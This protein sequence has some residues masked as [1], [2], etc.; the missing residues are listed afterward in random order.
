MDF[1]VHCAAAVP[2]HQAASGSQYSPL[3]CGDRRCFQT[4]TTTTL[5]SPPLP[6][7][8]VVKRKFDDLESCCAAEDSN[9]R[10]KEASGT[11]GGE[12]TG[13]GAGA[14]AVRRARCIPPREVNWS[15]SRERKAALSDGSALEQRPLFVLESH[16]TTPESKGSPRRTQLSGISSTN[17]CRVGGW[18]GIQQQP[19]DGHAPPLK[20]HLAALASGFCVG[21]RGQRTTMYSNVNIKSIEQREIAWKE[22]EHTIPGLSAL[23]GY[24]FG[25]SPRCVIMVNHATVQQ[26]E[27]IKLLLFFFFYFFSFFLLRTTKEPHILFLQSRNLVGKDRHHIFLDNMPPAAQSLEYKRV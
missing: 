20:W 7:L 15:R 10:G 26:G 24:R 6:P 16:A 13:A 4:T 9:K 19:L 21:G 12:V 27:F 14:G 18:R 8:T 5:L 11:L 22:R 3:L 17:S 1:T 25:F 2:H 23:E